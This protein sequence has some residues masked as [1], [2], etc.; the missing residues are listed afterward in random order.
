MAVLK[1]AS[2]DYFNYLRKY[3][4]FGPLFSHY[5]CYDYIYLNY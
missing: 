3:N 2:F 4:D 1:F 5:S